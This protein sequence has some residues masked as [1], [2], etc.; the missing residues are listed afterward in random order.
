ME[1]ISDWTSICWRIRYDCRQQSVEGIEIKWIT[2]NDYSRKE[3]AAGGER[4]NSSRDKFWKRCLLR[5]VMEKSGCVPFRQGVVESGLGEWCCLAPRPGRSVC[6]RVEILQA[7]N[8]MYFRYFSFLS[9]MAS[10][11]CARL[12]T[13]MRSVR[14]RFAVSFSSS[15]C[16][17]LNKSRFLKRMAR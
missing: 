16:L 1:F 10:R 5:K 3:T 11:L 8:Y 2:D 4:Q 15:R 9:A 17:V 13:N 14:L 7:S 12:A 6:K